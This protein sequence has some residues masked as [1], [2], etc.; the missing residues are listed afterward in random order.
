VGYCVESGQHTWE[1]QLNILLRLNEIEEDI[2]EAWLLLGLDK[3]E[4]EPLAGLRLRRTATHT[5]TE[6]QLGIWESGN[7]A[8]GMTHA[9]PG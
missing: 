8:A 1:L 6:R 3:E 7:R 2:C 5:H 4:K 9:S